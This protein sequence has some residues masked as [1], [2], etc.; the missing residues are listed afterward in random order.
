VHFIPLDEWVEGAW[1]SVVT[2]TIADIV[3][4][5]YNNH[6]SFFRYISTFKQWDEIK[7]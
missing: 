7:R 4:S 2:I 3:T 1:F 6:V 5:A